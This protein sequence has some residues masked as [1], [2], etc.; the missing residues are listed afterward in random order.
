MPPTH[1]YVLEL[2]RAPAQI[3]AAADVPSSSPTNAGNPAREAA[4]EGEAAPDAAPWTIGVRDF[5]VDPPY[6]QD[7]IVYRVGERSPEVGFYAYHL[8]AAPLS[9]ML[10]A[11]VAAGLTGTA[12]TQ[13]IEPV[14][15]GRRYDAFLLGRVLAVEEVDIGARQIVRAALELRLVGRDGAEIWAETIEARGETETAEVKQIVEALTAALGR[16]LGETRTSL[17]EALLQVTRENAGA[18]P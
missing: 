10:P 16:A 12:H 3:A 9:S 7:R 15:A 5:V 1:Y 17:G 6:N 18:T 8:W 11:V 4:A 2:D 14:D 13:E